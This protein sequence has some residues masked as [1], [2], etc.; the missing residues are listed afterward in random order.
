MRPFPDLDYHCCLGSDI[1]REFTESIDGDH[2][3]IEFW[4]TLDH[5]PR[6]GDYRIQVTIHK[7]KTR[8]LLGRRSSLFT[9]GESNMTRVR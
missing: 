1:V 8:E 7:V 5:V 9:R 6:W 2:G 3:V 4:I